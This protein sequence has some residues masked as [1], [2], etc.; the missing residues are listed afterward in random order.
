MQLY[1]FYQVGQ[2]GKK[3]NCANSSQSFRNSIIKEF[4]S[5]PFVLRL[6][7]LPMRDYSIKSVTAVMPNHI[8][9]PH[10][11]LTREKHIIRTSS[12]SLILILLLQAGS[13][14]L[15]LPGRFSTFLEFLMI[16]TLKNGLDYSRAEFYPGN[17]QKASAQFWQIIPV[18]GKA[19]LL[20]L[21]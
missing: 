8:L 21:I 2:P 15:N 6:Q 3:K 14:H 11:P 1:C 9:N 10:L 12:L 20:K 7:F 4:R 19:G 5:R 18:L 13:L 17:V 16:K